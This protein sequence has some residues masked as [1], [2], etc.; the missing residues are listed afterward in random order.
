[1]MFIAQIRDKGGRLRF[2]AEPADTRERA[3]FLAFRDGPA[4]ADTCSVS[5]AYRDG[6]GNWQSNGS[7]IRWYRR[8]DVMR[9]D[10]APAEGLFDA[11]ARD[12]TNLF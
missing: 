5:N 12:Q 10:Q 1:M 11:G 7:D 2:Q 9:A 8:R 6:A 3:A 4:K